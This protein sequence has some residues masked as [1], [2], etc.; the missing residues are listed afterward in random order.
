MYLEFTARETGRFGVKI[1]AWCLM[2]NHVHLIAVP[3]DGR[4]LARA[5]GEAH[6]WYSRMRN[7]AES[8]SLFSFCRGLPSSA[9][10]RPREDEWRMK[11][12]EG[13]LF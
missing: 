8:H 12:K 3:K 13:I 7:R 9:V 5:I 4:G 10:S 2:T 11:K 6:K 1:L